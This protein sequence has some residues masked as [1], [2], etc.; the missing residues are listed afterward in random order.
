MSLKGFLKRFHLP[1][2]GSLSITELIDTVRRHVKGEASTMD[3]VAAAESGEKLCA[4]SSGSKGGSHG[5]G[6]GGRVMRAGSGSGSSGLRSG[7]GYVCDAPPRDKG[8]LVILDLLGEG[9]FG[10]VRGRHP[11]MCCTDHNSCTHSTE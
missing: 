1:Q 5:S 3:V 6:G 4:L 2:S 9:A 8:D 10:K 11:I 7:S